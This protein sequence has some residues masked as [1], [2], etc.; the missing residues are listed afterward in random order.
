MKYVKLFESWLN[1]EDEKKNE[2]A[3]TDSTGSL[4]IENIS[5]MTIGDFKKLN[6]GNKGRVITIL[7]KSL[8]PGL[9]VKYLGVP[10]FDSKNEN[11]HVIFKGTDARPESII[12]KLDE[13]ND[14]DSIL[15]L[16]LKPSSES[17]IKGKIDHYTIGEMAESFNKMVKKSST[18]YTADEFFDKNASN[19][20]GEKESKTVWALLDA[21]GGKKMSDG[22]KNTA[23]AEI[24]DYLKKDT[25]GQK[26]FTQLKT[27][28]DA[29]FAPIVVK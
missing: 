7:Q 19:K 13:Q 16:K 11:E 28:I 6:S 20:S 4:G 17:V 2:P 24:S 8:F 29:K 15:N 14:G 12:A 1:E 25:Q 10:K 9:D 18:P 23:I 5:K 22:F 3:A 26:F 21:E 27:T